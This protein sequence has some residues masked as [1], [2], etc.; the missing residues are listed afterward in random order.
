MEAK[1]RFASA[2]V[3]TLRAPPIGFLIGQVDFKDLAIKLGSGDKPVL[4]KY[5]VF[6]QTIVDFGRTDPAVPVE[7]DTDCQPGCKVETCSCT[8]AGSYWSS[9]TIR[10]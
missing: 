7:F 9:S 1:R 3:A 4:I 2:P 10:P 8:Q 6:L 5:G